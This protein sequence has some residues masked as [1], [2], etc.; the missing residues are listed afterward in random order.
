MRK[1]KMVFH[2]INITVYGTLLDSEYP[3]MADDL[4]VF[5]ATPQKCYSHHTV[6]TGADILFKPLPLEHPPANFGNQ[7]NPLGNKV[8]YLCDI[9][10]GQLFW[11]G[12]YLCGIYGKCTEPL[13]TGGP[14]LVEIDKEYLDDYIR[15]CENLWHQ[16]S[17][18]HKLGTVT[19]SRKED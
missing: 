16:T 5:L 11:R 2:N 4:W 19:F 8:L 14:V 10:P 15:G 13:P 9:E 7:S 17:L 18:F 3:Q 6:S 12:Y 1:M